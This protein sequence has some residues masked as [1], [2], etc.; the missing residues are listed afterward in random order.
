MIAKQTGRR[1]SWYSQ[2]GVLTPC[3]IYYYDY[4]YSYT[5]AVAPHYTILFG[6]HLFEPWSVSE[7]C[8][9]FWDDGPFPLCK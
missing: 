4:Y 7:A 2:D 5:L 6:V 3:F 9:E 8:A 1:E